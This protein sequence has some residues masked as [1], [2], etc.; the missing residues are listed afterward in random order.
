MRALGVAAHPRSR[1]ENSLTDALRNSGLGSSPLTRGKRAPGGPMQALIRLIP[2]HAGKTLGC[3][4]RLIG[5]E[6]HPRSRGENQWRAANRNIVR[7]SSPLTRGKR[8][9]VRPRLRDRGLIPAHAGKTA[10][11]PCEMVGRGAH[12]RSR[13]E[14]PDGRLRGGFRFGSSPLTRGKPGPRRAH[15][16]HEGLIPAHAGKTGG[17]CGPRWCGRA[18]PRSR[19]ENGLHQ[20]HQLHDRGSSP[21]TRGK[22]MGRDRLRAGRGLIPAHA[23]KTGCPRRRS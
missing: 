16:D 7:G 2:A 12:P 3:S 5:Q 4:F 9:Q 10:C 8:H 19:G 18:H 11:R 6:A 1:G 20:R 22:H 17:W 15:T 23:G 21:L 13:G 14:N